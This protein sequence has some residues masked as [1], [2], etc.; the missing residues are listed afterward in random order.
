MCFDDKF[1]KQVTQGLFAWC[2]TGTFLIARW[3]LS[4]PPDWLVISWKQLLIF[5]QPSWMETQ[6]HLHF[7]IAGILMKTWLINDDIELFFRPWG[8]KSKRKGHWHCVNVNEWIVPCW[9]ESYWPVTKPVMHP[10]LP[11]IWAKTQCIMLKC[12]WTHHPPCVLFHKRNNVT[13]TQY[14]GYITHTHTHTGVKI[15][16]SLHRTWSVQDI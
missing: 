7:F 4:S 16:T 9:V 13:N 12:H 2:L 10:N 15:S 3:V 14:V 1:T 8:C 5:P 6:V 11:V